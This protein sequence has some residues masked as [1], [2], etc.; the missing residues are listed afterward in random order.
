MSS[1]SLGFLDEVE[2]EG[3]TFFFFLGIV[4]V[5]LCCLGWSQTPYLK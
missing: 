2:G 5:S 3:Q 4:E 1:P